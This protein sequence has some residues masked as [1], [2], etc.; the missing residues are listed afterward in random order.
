MVEGK[1]IEVGF[2]LPVAQDFRDEV[3]RP[4]PGVQVVELVV[5]HVTSLPDLGRPRHA[6]PPHTLSARRRTPARTAAVR[7]GYAASGL[8]P[9]FYRQ[10]GA[11]PRSDGDLRPWRRASVSGATGL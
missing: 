3:G 2:P 6:K 7:R 8:P 1:R 10:S 9:A 4:P 5:L 11:R